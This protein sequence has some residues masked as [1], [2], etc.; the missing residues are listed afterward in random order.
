MILSENQRTFISKLNKIP[1]TPKKNIHHW[2][3]YIELRC[4]TNI[5]GVVSQSDFLDHIYGRQ[6]DLREGDIDDYEETEKDDAANQHD[7]QEIFAQECFALLDN[8]ITLFGHYYPFCL[9]N[10]KMSIY[11][12]QELTNKNKTYLFF[13]F[14]SNLN[15]C[16]K[17]QN[18]LTSTFEKVSQEAMKNFLPSQGQCLYTGS[19]NVDSNGT[20]KIEGTF[21]DKLNQ[22]AN[23][24][25]TKVKVPKTDVIFKDNNGDGGLD[26]LA[27]IPMG[28]KQSHSILY[29]GQCACSP[30]DWVGKQNDIA[31]SKWKNYIELFVPPVNFMF[32]P[33][34]FRNSTG[35]WH[36]TTEIRDTVLIDRQRIIHNFKSKELML[37]TQKSY[38]IIE[39]LSSCK[40]P[41]V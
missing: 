22:I 10:D 40:A 36:S 7:K 12:N 8:R 1:S 38:K 19:S 6:E 24:L 20:Q 29:F 23:L 37:Q 3:D 2:A 15:Y 41:V 35:E 25:T 27:L 30:S 5:D 17:H 16:Q 28:D 14:C 26:I 4:L 39:E 13:L 11:L 31:Y 33:F 9:S 32:I 34:S 18:D 21:W